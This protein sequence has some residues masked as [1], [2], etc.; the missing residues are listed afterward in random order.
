MIRRCQLCA[1]YALRRDGHVLFRP[2]FAGGYYSTDEC[3]TTTD[4]TFTADFTR[5][6]RGCSCTLSTMKKRVEI[7]EPPLLDRE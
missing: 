5:D 1:P 3:S 6:Y 7:Y 4:I 2:S